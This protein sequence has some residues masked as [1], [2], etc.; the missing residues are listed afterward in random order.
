MNLFQIDDDCSLNIYLFR[1]SIGL[2]SMSSIFS[3]VKIHSDELIE[4][5]SGSIS[6]SSSELNLKQTLLGGQ[7]FR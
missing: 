2:M 5:S 1:S 4:Y 6:I 7:S 3:P